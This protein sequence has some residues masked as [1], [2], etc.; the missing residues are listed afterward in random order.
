MCFSMIAISSMLA[1]TLPLSNPRYTRPRTWRAR[2]NSKCST[3]VKHLS[4]GGLVRSRLVYIQ[5]ESERS[6]LPNQPILYIM[7]KDDHRNKISQLRTFLDHCLASNVNSIL[8]SPAPDDVGHRRWTVHRFSSMGTRLEVFL[9]D[10]GG[11]VPKPCNAAA[12]LRGAA[13]TIEGG[14]HVN[15][16]RVVIQR[17]QVTLLNARV[18]NHR[19][20]A[21]RLG[22]SMTASGEG[23]RYTDKHVSV[24]RAI[25]CHSILRATRLLGAHGWRIQSILLQPSSAC[26]R[27]A[28]MK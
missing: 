4:H 11:E 21:G 10:V 23:T 6:T 26:T 8:A 5:R 18:S 22:S 13:L 1:T 24:W 15:L 7:T 14:T 25:F 27:Q 2:F 20:Q 9:L 16:H 17:Q 19:T 3:I 12:A 28:K